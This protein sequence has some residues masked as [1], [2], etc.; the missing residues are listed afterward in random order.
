MRQRAQGR[1]SHLRIARILGL[2]DTTVEAS[3]PLNTPMVRLRADEDT[4]SA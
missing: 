4:P 3:E 1:V 2:L